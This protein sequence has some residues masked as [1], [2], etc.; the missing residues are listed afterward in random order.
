MICIHADT[1]LMDK[2][3]DV[4]YEHPAKFLGKKRNGDAR[5]IEEG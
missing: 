3:N 2:I 5:K 1:Q 4:D